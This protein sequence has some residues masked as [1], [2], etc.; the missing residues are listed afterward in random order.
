MEQISGWIQYR[1]ATE[2]LDPPVLRVRLRPIDVFN[3]AD[4]IASGGGAKMGA[5]TLSA[6]IEAVAEWDLESEG[7]PIPITPEN[8]SAYL[9]PIIAER[10]EGRGVGALLGIEILLDARNRD[11]FLKN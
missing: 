2:L 5:A 9:R 11:N 1:L 3:I 7:V 4:G 10:L 6:A 8:K